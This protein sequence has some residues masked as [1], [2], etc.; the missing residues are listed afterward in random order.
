MPVAWQPWGGQLCTCYRDL[1]CIVFWSQDK[2]QPYIHCQGSIPSTVQVLLSPSLPRQSPQ[3][4]FSK[5]ALIPTHS[6]IPA[7]LHYKLSHLQPSISHTP[8]E[9]DTSDHSFPDFRNSWYVNPDL[10]ELPSPLPS[11]DRE[12]PT[13]SA[14]ASRHFNTLAHS[15]S[16]KSIGSPV[17]NGDYIV[18]DEVAVA[19]T[20]HEE[21]RR[22]ALA[23]LV[24][25]L[26]LVKEDNQT[27]NIPAKDPLATAP[28]AWWT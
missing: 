27:K 9:S 2:E 5:T 10:T 19:I 20:N 16:Q 12:R 3:L 11:S 28:R 18:P 13:T 23:G 17:S 24:D 21:R 1:T 22:R 25:R 8:S 26:S 7:L 6:C 4:L 14:V 15:T